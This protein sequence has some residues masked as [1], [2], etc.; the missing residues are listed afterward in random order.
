LLYDNIIYGKGGGKKIEPLKKLSD[1][2]LINLYLQGD[3]EAKKV[4]F[5][6]YY[7]L[8]KSIAKDI[9]FQCKVQYKKVFSDGIKIYYRGVDSYNFKGSF[10]NF[11]IG[12]IYQNLPYKPKIERNE[13][14]WEED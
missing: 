14:F 12:Y 4:L 13:F 2:E 5:F 3:F 7:G 6:R 9:S 8:L 1:G 11:L 10:R